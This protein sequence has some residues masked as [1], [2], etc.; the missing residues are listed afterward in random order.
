MVGYGNPNR[1]ANPL[2]LQAG[3]PY[4]K[5]MPKTFCNPLP[6]PDYP[7]GRYTESP[8][9]F[10][11]RCEERPHFRELA[12]PSV[13]YWDGKWYLY[14][15]GRMVYVSEDFV[16]WE[17]KPMI[18]EDTGYA[19]TVV[20][21]QG[22]FYLTACG[23]PLFRSE[24]P[25]GPF[26]E[27]GPFLKP[28]GSRIEPWLDPMLF[29]DDDGR[30]YAY[31]GISDPGIFAAELDP[32][33]PNQL[34]SEPEI[35]F[36]YD[37]AHEWE[38][39]GDHNEDA[40]K[41]FVEGAWMLKWEGRYF[42]TYCGPGTEWKSY[43]QGTYVGDSPLGPFHYQQ[44]NPIL[45]G[46]H[47]LVNGP[48]HGCLVE[49]PEKTLW[50]FYTCCCCYYHVFE[51]RL[52]MDPA[53]IDEQG[54]LFVHG[55]TDTP[56]WA[57]GLK[58]SPEQGN[59][60]GWK[61]LSEH[62]PCQ[63]SSYSPGRNSAYALDPSMRTWWQPAAEDKQPWLE[64]N[65]QSPF[66]IQALRLIWSEHG[67]NYDEGIVPKAVSYVLSIQNE[68]GEWQPVVDARNPEK[69]LMI[70]YREFDTVEGQKLKLQILD[71]PQHY[72]LGL[73]ALTLFGTNLG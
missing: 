41:S 33:Q 58:R 50:A 43:A 30:L 52:G 22:S 63:A 13:L 45:Q 10:G 54:N 38:R 26:E 46:R 27:L 71:P 16:N 12:D 48:G 29:S 21:H 4:A 5:T 70:E 35:L 53:G 9:Q 23:A 28:D 14:P 57:P 72:A 20:E 51:R 44:R 17:W 40:S 42:L 61:I 18:P 3:G 2:S 73:T 34:I 6:I 68:A 66:R 69:E 59:D 36:A 65:L 19:P 64:I 32:E 11:W 31:W 49:G 56:Q 15:S 60:A 47:G 25:I 8:E 55:S 62:K 67:L 1:E 24:S 39:Y 7:R 37:P